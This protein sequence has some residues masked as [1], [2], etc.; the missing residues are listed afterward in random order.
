MTIHHSKWKIIHYLPAPCFLFVQ[1]SWPK[2]PPGFKMFNVELPT[3]PP[4]RSAGPRPWARWPWRSAPA[5]RSSRA[6][7]WSEA[8]RPRAARAP[9]SPRWP[10]GRRSSGA[11][12]SPRKT[13]AHASN[14]GVRTKKD[15]WVFGSFV[16]MFFGVGFWWTT[17]FVKL[18]KKKK[19]DHWWVRSFR[20]PSNRYTSCVRWTKNQFSPRVSLR[21]GKGPPCAHPWCCE[22]GQLH[23]SFAET[24]SDPLKKNEKYLTILEANKSFLVFARQLP[25][26]HEISVAFPSLVLF[27]IP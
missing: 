10:C 1:S 3:P 12:S 6:P 19:K 15:G 24:T 14:P 18:A 16:W 8:P 26:Y 9:W 17:F 20:Y 27:N 4:R 21:T 5:A 25:K 11:R 7:G 23:P 2:L 22:W 13:C